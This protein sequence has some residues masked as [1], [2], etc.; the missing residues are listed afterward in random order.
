M[1]VSSYA[2]FLASAAKKTDLNYIWAFAA[3]DALT[4]QNMSQPLIPDDAAD[5]A[6]TSPTHWYGGQPVNAAW[7]DKFGPGA[8]LPTPDGGWPLLDES[9]AIVLTEA[10]AALA[11][12]TRYININ[13]GEDAELLPAQNLA[14]VL[15]ALHLAK[16]PPPE[17]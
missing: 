8:P 10:N 3:G 6:N 9:D 16:P 5:P 12:A 17:I 11:W 14:T 7:V 4:A 13:T 1:P 2:V 15:A